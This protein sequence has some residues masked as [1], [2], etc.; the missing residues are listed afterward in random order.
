MAQE[1]CH[2]SSL[3]WDIFINEQEAEANIAV[4]KSTV[5]TNLEGTARCQ[6]E[7]GQWQ[8]MLHM[9]TRSA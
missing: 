8:Q 7:E 5:D 3:C 1:G 4:I 9:F 6:G 2:R